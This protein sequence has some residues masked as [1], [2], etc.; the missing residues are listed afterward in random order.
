MPP[1]DTQIHLLHEVPTPRD[2][3]YLRF[4][5]PFGTGSRIHPSDSYCQA[6]TWKIDISHS[7]N[8]V[9]QAGYRSALRWHRARHSFH[10]RG[11]HLSAVLLSRQEAIS[12]ADKTNK[13]VTSIWPR[14]LPDTDGRGK[15]TLRTRYRALPDLPAQWTEERGAMA[16]GTSAGSRA[17]ACLY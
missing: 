11:F 5:F 2:V 17:R 12:A 10:R 7:A 9:C 6:T 1:R 16:E 14:P 15:A 4:L 13:A 8:Q 3:R